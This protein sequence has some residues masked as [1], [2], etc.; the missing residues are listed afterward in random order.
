MSVK[1]KYKKK[2]RYL[3]DKIQDSLDPDENAYGA[4]YKVN[5]LLYP[6]IDELSS[7]D[8]YNWGIA[9]YSIDSEPRNNAK[10]KFLRALQID[11]DNYLAELYLSHCYHD[12]KNYKEAL[13]G[14]LKVAD[15]NK[16]DEL[17][18]IWRAAKLY[19]QIGY[20]YFKLGKEKKAIEYF[21]VV[22]D[23]YFK[24]HD[25]DKF[26][27]PTDMLECIPDTHEI[28]NNFDINSII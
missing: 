16:I 5:E 15:T 25:V 23:E 11:E 4:L 26:V 20:C 6:I 19:E 1:Y 8:F 17:L 27:K 2:L 9:H 21:K 24:K 12:E 7:N 22:V 28:F 10:V 18:Y 3:V 14:Y 13:K